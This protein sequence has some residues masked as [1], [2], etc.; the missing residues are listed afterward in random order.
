MALIVQLSLLQSS[1]K[2]PSNQIQ[3]YIYTPKPLGIHVISCLWYLNQLS[4]KRYVPVQSDCIGLI[5]DLLYGN[6]VAIKLV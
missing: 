6:P 2:L 4:L 3:V 1:L 5:Q